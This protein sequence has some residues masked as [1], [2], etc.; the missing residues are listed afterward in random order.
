MSKT[1]VISRSFLVSGETQYDEGL[2]YIYIVAATSVTSQLHVLALSHSVTLCGP[3]PPS[4]SV[5]CYW[6]TCCLA[7]ET[8]I[9]AAPRHFKIFIGK[10]EVPL[11]KTKFFFDFIVNSWEAI[12]TVLFWNNFCLNWQNYLL[13]ISVSHYSLLISVLEVFFGCQRF[14]FSHILTSYLLWNF[15]FFF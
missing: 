11:W 14:H 1:P 5:A 12:N 15:W 2:L 10:G 3:P 7:R 8:S 4:R 9:T 13:M 6:I